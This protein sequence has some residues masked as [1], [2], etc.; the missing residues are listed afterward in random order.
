ML[1]GFVYPAG[2]GGSQSFEQQQVASTQEQTFSDGLRGGE[3]EGQPQEIVA[4]W[5]RSLFYPSSLVP[6]LLTSIQQ[7][8]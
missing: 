1:F 8:T 5:L 2:K 3:A 6:P 7:T 4:L